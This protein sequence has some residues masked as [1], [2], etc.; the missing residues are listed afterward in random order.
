MVSEGRM[1]SLVVD[2]SLWLESGREFISFFNQ[3][4][5]WQIVKE[6]CEGM[7]PY[8]SLEE[9]ML[10]YYYFYLKQWNSLLKSKFQIFF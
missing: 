10:Y 1:A 8:L 9:L 3:Y 5:L 2:T 6:K 7:I 4:N